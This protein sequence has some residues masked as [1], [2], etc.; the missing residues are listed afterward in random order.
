[1]SNQSTRSRLPTVPVTGSCPNLRPDGG[2]LLSEG[3]HANL[4]TREAGKVGQHLP[5]RN[6]IRMP[7]RPVNSIVKLRAMLCP[8]RKREQLASRRRPMGEVL[9]VPSLRTVHRLSA[10]IMNSVTETLE[11]LRA[12]SKVQSRGQA[13]LHEQLAANELV[14]NLR[15]A[16]S[17]GAVLR[18][19]GAS[20]VN[21]AGV[22]RHFSTI[23]I[24]T[25]DLTRREC[26]R[27]NP[28][29]NT[30]GNG[31]STSGEMFALQ[32]RPLGGAR[33]CSLASR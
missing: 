6:H 9:P 10:E 11:R 23:D 27:G 20:G 15:F 1:M 7:A 5:R 17:V 22:P 29:I 21:P 32:P 12:G 18:E 2:R 13:Y 24:L 14:R 31:N 19:A 3:S 25:A 26:G 33:N 30:D 4:Q 16:P 28:H 8:S